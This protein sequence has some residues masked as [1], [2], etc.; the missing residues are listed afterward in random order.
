[1][2]NRLE[3]GTS[4]IVAAEIT[5]KGNLSERGSNPITEEDFKNLQKE[6]RKIAKKISREILKG[7]I[8]IK[9]YKEGKKTACSYCSY[10]SICRFN[11]NIKGNEY[12]KIKSKKKN[13]ILEEIRGK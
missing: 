11:T 3:V 5:S 7:K 12:M 13:E 4:D 8:D 6:V 9:P 10:K 2:D 1:M